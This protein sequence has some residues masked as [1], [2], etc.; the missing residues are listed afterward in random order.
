MK[1]CLLFLLLA[2]SA[3]GQTYPMCY[4]WCPDG[5]QIG[6]S[7]DEV[8]QGNGIK[9]GSL[10]CPGDVGCP[11]NPPPFGQCPASC[12]CPGMPPCAN[13]FT[14]VPTWMRPPTKLELASLDLIMW[15]HIA[16]KRV[17]VAAIW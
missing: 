7:C 9:P 17:L 1:T 16:R 6:P 4:T 5:T 8:C 13:G 10:N 14:R 12:G 2:A 11:G 15:N 3:Y